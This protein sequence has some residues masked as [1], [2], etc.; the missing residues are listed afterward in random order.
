MFNII[1]ALFL[2]A[3]LLC[4]TDPFMVFMPAPMQ[5][6]ALVCAAALACVWAGFVMLEETHDERELLHKLHA[7]RIAYL[8]GIAVLTV[9]LV[10]QGIA[11]DIDPFIPL[12]LGT[13]VLSKLGT[14]L[15]FEWYR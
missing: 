2:V 4:V 11:H 8:S 1:S 5:M 15:Y 7:G 14:R 10:V 12:A 13:M 6:L 9:A 3:L